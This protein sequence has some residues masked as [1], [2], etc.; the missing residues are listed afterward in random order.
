MLIKPS[1]AIRQNYGEIS[2]ICRESAEPVYLTVNGGGDL[3]VMSI[4]AFERREKMLQLREKLLRVE[5]DR[6]A[7]REGCTVN[8]LDSYLTGVIRE[9]ADH[10]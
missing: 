9:V 1:S 5:E 8:E 6:L 7:G 4:E 10:G 2:R 3:A